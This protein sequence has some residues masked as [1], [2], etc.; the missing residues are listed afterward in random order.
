VLGAFKHHHYSIEGFSATWVNIQIKH[1]RMVELLTIL[2]TTIEKNSSLQSLISF[3]K[4]SKEDFEA[5][6]EVLM[7]ILPS[8]TLESMFEFL[9]AQL[10]M[11]IGAYP[12]LNLTEAQKEAMDTVGMASDPGFY[13]AIYT[14][15]IQYLIQ[16]LSQK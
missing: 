7:D 3:K 4:K 13:K 12:M 10:A 6:A 2:F 11:A 9:F 16:G 15:S 14:N 1:K 8:F 5:I